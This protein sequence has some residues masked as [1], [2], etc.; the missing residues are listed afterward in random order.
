[1]RFS[2]FQYTSKIAIVSIVQTGRY[3]VGCTSQTYTLSHTFKTL[4]SKRN[5]HIA[6]HAE[7][8]W[9]EQRNTEEG[10]EATTVHV[11]YTTYT[12]YIATS[13]IVQ[14]NYV[15]VHS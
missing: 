2:R 12:H 11:A 3:Y 13:V 8:L 10:E 7:K 4:H 9:C 5:L 6:V 15:Q 14:H 1:M